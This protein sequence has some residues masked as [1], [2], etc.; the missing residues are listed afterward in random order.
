M[1]IRVITS[2]SLHYMRSPAA[3]YA[4]SAIANCPLSGLKVSSCHR[5]TWP[6]ACKWF[7][8]VVCVSQTSDNKTAADA[9]CVF[10]SF[11]VRR[12]CISSAFARQQMQMQRW[13]SSTQRCTQML[14]QFADAFCSVR[15]P[16]NGLALRRSCSHSRGQQ[17][18]GH[19]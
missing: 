15:T 11:C 4:D 19:A 2:M 18:P 1:Y 14:C 10:L 16:A 12:R 13:L 7:G 9:F 5:S 6:H 3:F 8:S 17:Q